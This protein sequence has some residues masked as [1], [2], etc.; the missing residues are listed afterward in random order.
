MTPP[1]IPPP[2]S[3][4]AR[5][6][7]ACQIAGWGG[8]GLAQL[9]VALM[10][11]HLPALRS[12]LELAL[13]YGVALTFS[14]LLRAHARRRGWQAL[15][16]AALVPRIVAAS[17]LLG[18]PLGLATT[19]LMVGA[20]HSPDSAAQMGLIVPPSSMLETLLVD[21]A[22]WSLLFAIWCTLYFSIVAARRRRWAEL[23]R[24][25]LARALQSA[26]LRLLKS[27]L[28]P[29]FLF[30]S[31]NSVRALIAD[32]PARAQRA[33]TQLARTL[34]YTLGSGQEEL[35]TLEQELEIV[36]DYLELEALRLGARLRIERDIAADALGAQIPV[37]LLQTVVENA[38]KHGVAECPDGGVLR[39]AARRHGAELLLE[40]GNPRPATAA[41]A[42]EGIGLRNAQE[43]LRLLFGPAARLDLDLAAPDRA[44]ARVRIP[45]AA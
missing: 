37:M 31:L 32:D 15:R 14:H 25:E 17:V 16:L 5:A 22:N 33:V 30:N 6:Y 35:V 21:V 45:A 2:P 19:P 36:D 10:V 43:R 41:P 27:Q 1:A 9:W 4:S 34:R 28:N 42:G 20:L 39:I 3:G 44:F 11:L 23:Q 8:Y 24:S 7:W 13:L 38:I 12:V 40:V 18:V 26:E 29:H